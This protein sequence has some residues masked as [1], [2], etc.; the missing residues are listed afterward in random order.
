MENPRIVR[1]AM[2]VAGV[3]RNPKIEYTPTV[4]R[5]SCTRAARVAAA[6]FHS[7]RRAM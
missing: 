3:T 4:T 1:S 6:I 2:T 5:M 7:K